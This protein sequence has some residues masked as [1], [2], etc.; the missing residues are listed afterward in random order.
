MVSLE[1][2]CQERRERTPHHF[3]VQAE[4]TNTLFDKVVKSVH[5]FAR[6]LDILF[7]RRKHPLNN[8]HLSR[9]N[10]LLS[11]KAPLPSLCTFL[12]KDVVAL[13]VHADEVDG[14]QA[15]SGGVGDE[16][17]AGVLE[18]FA[19][20]GAGTADIGGVVFAGNCEYEKV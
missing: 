18:F 3:S 12:F 10:R 13:V 8:V 9:V 11:R 20:R 4:S 7:A 6:K 1:F 17:L 5:H 2:L 14:L 19:R 15:K 16:C